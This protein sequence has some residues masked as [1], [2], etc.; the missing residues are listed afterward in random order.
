[1]AIEKTVIPGEG[2]PKAWDGHLLQS[3]G[4]IEVE[5]LVGVQSVT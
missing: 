5:L 1:L 4:E 3:E 2:L